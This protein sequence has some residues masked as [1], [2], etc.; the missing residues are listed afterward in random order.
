MDEKQKK[1]GRTRG[2]AAKK[3]PAK[4]KHP[5]GRPTKYDPTLN[6]KVTK[7]LLMGATLEETA[8]FL[9]IAR[10]NMDLWR[11][12]H[13]EFRDAIEKGLHANDATV[14]G[15]LFKRAVGQVV[16][17][18][19]V[20]YDKDVAAAMMRACAEAVKVTLEGQGASEIDIAIAIDKALKDLAKTNP[21]VMVVKYKEEI[22]ADVKA[23]I[24]YLT[25]RRARNWKERDQSEQ[26]G[27]EAQHNVDWVPAAGCEP[28]RD[29]SEIEAEGAKINDSD[30][31]N[32]EVHA[33]I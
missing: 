26:P 2:P 16:K 10:Q 28:L 18:E 20:V 32:N 15:K 3:A 11:K 22:P 24:F 6:D 25:N 4:K 21:G 19:K 13:P 30:Y 14:A 5:G 31:G 17:K 9:G 8:D 1:P 7:Y 12:K 27:G 33:S 23:Q 29:I